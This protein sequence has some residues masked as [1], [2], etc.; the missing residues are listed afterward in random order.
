MTNN[1][2]INKY[3]FESNGT[4]FNMQKLKKIAVTLQL[5]LSHTRTIMSTI[6]AAIKSFTHTH[7]IVKEKLQWHYFIKIL[8]F[9]RFDNNKTFCICQ[10]IL[11]IQ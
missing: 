11:I 10:Y 6:Y 2:R 4:I 5:I 7:Y 3:K 9:I 8:N 1:K